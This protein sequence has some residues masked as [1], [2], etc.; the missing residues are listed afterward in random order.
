MIKLFYEVLPINNFQRQICSY[1]EKT[2]DEDI[3][4]INAYSHIFIM[5]TNY[6]TTFL[7]PVS[8]K[9]PHGFASVIYRWNGLCF[10][11]MCLKMIP[12]CQVEM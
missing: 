8:R 6:C 4:E 10:G 11:E 2:N 5:I 3:K 9:R 7:A 12:L 1:V